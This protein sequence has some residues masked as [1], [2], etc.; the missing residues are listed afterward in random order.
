MT[1]L[2]RRLPTR[3]EMELMSTKELQKLAELQGHSETA[4]IAREEIEFRRK[5]A[6]ECAVTINVRHG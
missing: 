1:L 2:K 6:S 5:F 4:V 3:A